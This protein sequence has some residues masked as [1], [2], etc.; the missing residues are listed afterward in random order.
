MMQQKRAGREFSRKTV[1]RQLVLIWEN[2]K[3]TRSKRCMK[4]IT[5]KLQGLKSYNSESNTLCT[6]APSWDKCGK[7]CWDTRP[8]PAVLLTCGVG[9]I[10]INPMFP[11]VWSITE[12]LLSKSKTREIWHLWSAAW[13]QPSPMSDVVPAPS[14]ARFEV[15]GFL[16]D[17]TI[18]PMV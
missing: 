15:N 18:W 1:M 3:N 11:L 8:M 5:F 14:F 10:G 12:K 4:L 2:R 7:P 17:L 9:S 16:L 13:W 6:Q